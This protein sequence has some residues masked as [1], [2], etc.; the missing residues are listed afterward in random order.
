MVN[1]QWVPNRKEIIHLDDVDGAGRE[2]AGDRPHLVLTKQGYNDKTS[3]VVCV[4][5]STQVKG[6][7]FETSIADLNK[8]SVA[9]TNR[10]TTADWRKRNAFHRGTAT[11][12]EMAEVEAKIKALLFP[13]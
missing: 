5:I 3:L 7:P 6:N 13:S 2:Q 4:P 10:V 8:T 9:L 12:A 11:D 1:P